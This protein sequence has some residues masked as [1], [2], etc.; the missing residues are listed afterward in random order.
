MFIFL[1]FFFF[2]IENVG[3]SK[4][5][6]LNDERKDNFEEFLKYSK[7]TGTY[8]LIKSTLG[9]AISSL[10]KDAFIFDPRSKEDPDPVHKN[11]NHINQVNFI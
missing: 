2:V 10:V 3:N 9:S 6:N 5:E 7:K 11:H 8:T 1:F 4:I